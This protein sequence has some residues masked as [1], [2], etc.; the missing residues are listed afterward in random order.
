MN[1]TKAIAGLLALAASSASMA[2]VVLSEDFD[3][4]STLAGKGWAIQN[5]STPVG[6]STWF[7]GNA[8]AG[9]ANGAAGSHIG[10]NF[11][12]AA[13][14][15]G[16]I[17]NWLMTPVVDMASNVSMDFALRLLGGGFLDTVQVYYSVAGASTNVADFLLLDT[18]A[19]SVDTGWTL[20]HETLSFLATSGT[21]R[22][23]FRYFVG[24]T[25]VDG[26]Y[27]GIDAVNVNV[28]VS[29]VPEP[30]SIALLSLG[31]L[32]VAAARRRNA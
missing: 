2:A 1:F 6:P 10:A 9:S 28:N 18:Y 13:T 4:V 22:F 8:T 21:G 24:D 32:G 29:S 26:N 15:G 14:D 12:S 5:L 31:L 30:A 7:Q 23:A 20:K 3:D 27:V 19:S 17:S 11:L 25:L 16:T